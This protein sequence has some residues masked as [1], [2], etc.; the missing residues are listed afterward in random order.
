[1]TA[2][3]LRPYQTRAKNE[4]LAY[5]QRGA[6]GV[7]IESPV[8]SGKTTIGMDIVD[9]VMAAGKK[10]VWFTHRQELRQQAADRA[11][12][13]DLPYAQ[14]LPGHDVTS[15]Q[16]HIASI[17]TV[18]ARFSSLQPWLETID[19]A[20]F[21]EAHHLTAAGWSKIADAMKR[22]QKAGLTATAFRLDGKGLGEGGHFTETVRCPGIK[23]LTK[24]GY[25]APAIVY[26]PPTGLDMS[27]VGKIGGDY[28]VNQMAAAVKDA[29]LPAIGRKWYAK[30]APGQPAIVFCPTVEQAEASAAAYREAGWRAYSV[31]G[32]M[33]DKDRA[34]VV[35]GLAD[36][37]T[38]VLTS[39]AIVSEGFDAPAVAV[40]ILERPTA[41]TGLYIQMIGRCLRPHEDK[42]HAVI[43]DLVKNAQHH[44]MYDEPR[45]WDLRAGLKGLER[46]VAATWRCTRCHRVH[47]RPNETVVMACGC[48]SNQKTHGIAPANVDNLPGINGVA[49]DV[50]YRLKLSDA[51][52]HCHSLRDYETLGKIK[53]YK[54]GWAVFAW[55][56]ANEMRRRF[57]PRRAS[58]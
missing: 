45:H 2:P 53:N 41:S 39:C 25:L 43:L 23:A 1:M 5:L 48:G 50:L 15:H 46:A 26:A 32:S 4:T 40:C 27:K 9:T 16:L 57:Q 38:Q 11:D 56:K 3:T 19:L 29:N 10:V 55:E 6:T 30:H 22:S 18:I 8:G 13:Y 31:D 47:S 7:L 24:A 44:G 58:R 14:I 52:K 42:T 35:G 36:G 49:A 34:R 51:L 20:V 12:L 21:D 28:K 17:D 54:K 33:S 37:S